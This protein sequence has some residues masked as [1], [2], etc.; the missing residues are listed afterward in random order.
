MHTAMSLPL[1]QRWACAYRDNEFHAAVD[2]NNGTEAQNK[3]LK[4]KYMP[5]QRAST[6]SALVSL[7]VERFLPE[8][9][10]SYVLPNLKT[11]EWYRRYNDFVPRFLRGRPRSVILHC[12]D[13]QS[14]S[15]KYHDE[16]L[17][18]G[19]KEGAFIIQRKDG[20]QY[21]VDFGRNSQYRCHLVPVKTGLDGTSHANT[22]LQCFDLNKHGAGMHYH[23][24]TE[25]VHTYQQ[26][27]MPLMHTLPSSPLML[28]I[29]P[30]QFL[31][32]VVKYRPLL[33]LKA[34][35]KLLSS[36]RFL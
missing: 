26:T 8:A 18:D 24:H 14:R 12:I 27:R 32:S 25:T 6:L 21:M 4:Y 11:A 34:P 1:K 5:K 33:A 13:R 15:N 19:E 17:I 20:A 2:T 9:Q 29:L 35:C 28:K 16:D 31:I 10:Q 22:S 3:V 23:K 36:S 30:S 7:L